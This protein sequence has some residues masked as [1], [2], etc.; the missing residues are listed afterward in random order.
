MTGLITTAFFDPSA[1]SGKKHDYKAIVVGSLFEAVYYVRYAFIRRCTTNQVLEELY[2]IDRDFPDVLLGFEDNG[3]QVLYKDLL[4]YK[5]KEKNYPL[6]IKTLTSTSKKESRIESLASFIQDGH[7]KFHYDRP[8]DI[9]DGRG[10][11]SGDIHLLVNQLLEFPHGRHDDGPDALYYALSLARDKAAKA[12]FGSARKGGPPNA[13]KRA[14]RD[15]EKSRGLRGMWQ[16]LK[17]PF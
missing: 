6:R 16:R 12:A 9:E 4:D 2:R 13:P 1:R 10:A 17:N 7:I 3:F 11:F 5:A 15:P 14:R 8:P